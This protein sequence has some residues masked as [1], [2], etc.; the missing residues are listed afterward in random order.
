[1]GHERDETILTYFSNL[2][3]F[4]GVFVTIYAKS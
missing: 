1:M 4:V 3:V 2:Y